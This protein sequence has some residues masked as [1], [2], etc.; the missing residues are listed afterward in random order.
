M[1]GLRT[2]NSPESGPS[3]QMLPGWELLRKHL[4]IVDSFLFAIGSLEVASC[5]SISSVLERKSS[6]PSG[7]A[8]PN[9][10][11]YSS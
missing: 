7:K 9:P 11:L 4:S 10:N 6:A 5:K 2:L 8:S 1:E 3:E